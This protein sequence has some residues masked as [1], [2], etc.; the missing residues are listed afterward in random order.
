MLISAT[1]FPHTFESWYAHQADAYEA[2]WQATE[3]RTQIVRLM[4]SYTWDDAV[5]ELSPAC[6]DPGSSIRNRPA[7]GVMQKWALSVR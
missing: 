2:W 5:N 3:G 6:L 4:G 1:S 7:E